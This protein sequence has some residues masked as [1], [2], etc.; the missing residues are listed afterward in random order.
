MNLD[1]LRPSN[2][3]EDLLLSINENCKTLIERT[4]SK[5]L[6]T[7][8][9]KPIKPWEFFSF[10]PSNVLGLDSKWMIGLTC[11]EVYNSI[12]ISTEGNFEF[13]FHTDLF[14]ESSFT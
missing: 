13:E 7:L 10:K 5:P 11:L 8:E 12:F 3:T 1:K 4:H 14:N 6:E 2:E 9:A